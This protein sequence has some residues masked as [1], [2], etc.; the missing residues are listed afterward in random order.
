MEFVDGG[1]K[2]GIQVRRVHGKEMCRAI[3]P[4][5]TENRGIS[6]TLPRR[7]SNTRATSRNDAPRHRARRTQPNKP[8]KYIPQPFQAIIS[9]STAMKPDPF[10]NHHDR[11][12]DLAK[13]E[14]VVDRQDEGS[15][16]LRK[17]SRDHNNNK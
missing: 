1:V 14:I 12:R 5:G 9:N 4:G 2:E 7:N 13:R 16:G 6:D 17:D 3:E 11:A 8:T 10:S 15:C